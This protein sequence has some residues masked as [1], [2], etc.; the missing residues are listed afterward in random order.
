MANVKTAISLNNTLFDQVNDLADE[1]NISRS[2][3]FALAVEE[4][5]Q[6]HK[7]QQILREINQAYDDFPDSTEQQL[8]DGM[9]QHHRRVITDQW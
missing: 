6:R 7:N 8:Q 5:I 2:R 3:L 9:H 4:Y 1:M